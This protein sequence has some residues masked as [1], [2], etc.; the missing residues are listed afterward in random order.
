MNK[1]SRLKYIPEIK[2]II[3]KDGISG[4]YRGFWATFL[5][6]VPGWAYFFGAY[7]QYKKIGER[8]VPKFNL[9]ED[10]E[11]LVQMFWNI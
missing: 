4:L 5:C 6:V 10:K 9:P 11:K 3:K 2:N 1:E 8:T 7:E